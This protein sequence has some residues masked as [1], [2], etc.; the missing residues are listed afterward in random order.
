MREPQQPITILVAD[1]D[2][3]DRLLLTEALA[4]VQAHSDV[5][6]VENGEELLDYLWRRGRYTDLASAPC[7]SLILLDLNMPKKNGWEALTEIRADAALAHVP[8]VVLTTSRAQEDVLRSY[9][10]GAN[11][12]ITKPST[13]AGLVDF[14]QG[15]STYWREAVQRP[16]EK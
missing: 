9:A 5:R 2:P 7:P 15:I 13:Y 14:M 6:W 11:S 3:E 1:D 4:E 8:I 12:F 16:G 10:L